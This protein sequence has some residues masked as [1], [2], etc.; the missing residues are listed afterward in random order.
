MS[1][2]IPLGAQLIPGILLAIGCLKLPAS[3]RLLILRGKME[4][5]RQTLRQL[6]ISTSQGSLASQDSVLLEKLVG[7]EALNIQ[8]EVQLI[9]EVEAAELPRR[10]PGDN[11]FLK[12]LSLWRLLFE[13]RYLK[14]VLV[15]VVVMV[16][17]REFL[18]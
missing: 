7:L 14:R 3:P 15:G 17:Q 10:S 11:K 9:H 5:G 2:R 12:E 1:W 8:A 18:L 4:Q 16:F 13:S 6:R